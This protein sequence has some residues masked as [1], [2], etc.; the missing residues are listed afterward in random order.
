MRKTV[1]KTLNQIGKPISEVN[2]S[3]TFS[4]SSF[5]SF[6][7]FIFFILIIITILYLLFFIFKLKKMFSIKNKRKKDF[8]YLEKAKK[9]LE[10]GVINSEE[11]DKILD[12]YKSKY[13]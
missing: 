2:S 12:E 5:E 9:E 3:I 10:L 6:A 13:Q 11:Y 7:F 8:H 1:K 4:K